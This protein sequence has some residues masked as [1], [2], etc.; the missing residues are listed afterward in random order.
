MKTII[1]TF[2]FLLTFLGFSQK[3]TPIDSSQFCLPT[4]IVKKIL[5]D[6]NE[7]DRLK[8][9]EEIVVLEIKELEKKI[10]K[11]DSIILNLE[12]KDENYKLIINNWEEKYN[13]VEIDNKELRKKLKWSNIK[14][15]IVEIVSGVL[16][17]SLIYLQFF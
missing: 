10:T 9:N 2:F 15:N 4:K 8:K 14:T 3:E 16:L 11:Q 12:K 5:L 6:L 7:L 13:L 1:T 17:T